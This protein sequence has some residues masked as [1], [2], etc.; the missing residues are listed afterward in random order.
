MGCCGRRAG[1]VGRKMCSMAAVG[2]VG[3]MCSTGALGDAVIVCCCCCG[4]RASFGQ[5]CDCA[6]PGGVGRGEVGWEGASDPAVLGQRSLEPTAVRAGPGPRPDFVGDVLER[7]DEPVGP[8][9]CATAGVR[10][11]G[12]PAEV[13]RGLDL[14]VDCAGVRVARP[15]VGVDLIGEEPGLNVQGSP[16]VERVEAVAAEVAVRHAGRGHAYDLD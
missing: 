5:G 15:A 4:L 12:S 7:E 11:L 10:A 2:S 1:G 3:S 9:R 14:L 16:H 13:G 8:C 6:D